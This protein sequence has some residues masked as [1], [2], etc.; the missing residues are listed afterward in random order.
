MT[1]FGRLLRDDI[2]STNSYSH[3]SGLTNIFSNSKCTKF[4]P[5]TMLG[6]TDGITIIVATTLRRI[7]DSNSRQ[8]VGPV[9]PPQWASF[10]T[11]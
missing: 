10:R 5:F 7:W 3:S 1:F 8:S 6:L 4:T 2:Q 11:L 9:T